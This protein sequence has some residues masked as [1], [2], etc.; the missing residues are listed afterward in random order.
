MASSRCFSTGDGGVSYVAH[1]SSFLLGGTTAANACAQCAAS[2]SRGRFASHAA[3]RGCMQQ[4]RHAQRPCAAST[5]LPRLSCTALSDVRSIKDHGTAHL[6]R[7][8]LCASAHTLSQVSGED[9]MRETDPA[10]A[11]QQSA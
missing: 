4:Y 11:M 6:L 7:L 2:I 3:K 9:I 10:D 5:T 1:A 8:V